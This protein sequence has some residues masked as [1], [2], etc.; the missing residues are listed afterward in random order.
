MTVAWTIV[1]IALAVGWCWGYDQGV[2]DEDAKWLKLWPKLARTSY[3]MAQA[4]PMT[5]DEAVQAIVRGMEVP[6]H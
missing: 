3:D 5:T 2:R 1:A 4:R 6:K